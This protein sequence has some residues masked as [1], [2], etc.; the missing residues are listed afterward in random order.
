MTD[1]LEKAYHRIS[2]LHYTLTYIMIKNLSY[3]I[4]TILKQLVNHKTTM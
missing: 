2:Q 3:N 1:R 4:S